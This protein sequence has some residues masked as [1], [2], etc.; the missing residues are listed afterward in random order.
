MAEEAEAGLDL[1]VELAAEEAEERG[2]MKSPRNQFG[3]S[4][5]TLGGT[6]PKNK[7]LSSRQL[8]KLQVKI[9]GRMFMGQSVDESAFFP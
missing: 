6:G 2:R 4:S 9:S 8:Y 5:P 3:A 7:Y 1:T